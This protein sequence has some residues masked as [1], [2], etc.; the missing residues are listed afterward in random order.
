M[1]SQTSLQHKKQYKL[2]LINVSTFNLGSEWV[3]TF[4]RKIRRKI[5]ML[6]AAMYTPRKNPRFFASFEL[7][8][9]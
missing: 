1:I 5:S 2:N 7:R 6:L 4:R 8:T 3:L 9:S